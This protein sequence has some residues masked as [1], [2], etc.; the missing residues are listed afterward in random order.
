MKKRILT[1]V[2]AISMVLSLAACGNSA[3]PSNTTPS[4]AAPSSSASGTP[5]GDASSKY[6]EAT[7]ALSSA[8]F[9]LS[10]FGGDSGSR[11]AIRYQLYDFLAVQEQFGEPVDKLQGQMAKSMTMKN[12][13]TCEV[14]L[15]DYIKDC[16]GN[17][18]KASDVVWAYEYAKKQGDFGKIG[19]YMKSIKAMDDFTVEIVANSAGAGVMETLL[20]GVP[21]VSQ[22]WFEG[23]SDS[24]KTSNPAC[25]GTYKITE[26]VTGSTVVVEAV[27]DY[28]QTD[29]AALS[30]LGHQ[31]VDKIT[32]KVITEAAM[33][34]I[35][36]EN[37]ELDAAPVT[38]TEVHRFMNDDGSSKDGW[39]VLANE[40]GR[41]NVLMFNCDKG[42]VFENKTLRQAVLYAI[43]FEQVRLG[44]GN[45]ASSG[46]TMHD[47]CVPVAGDYNKAWDSEDYYSHNVEKA[48]TL[49][50]EAGYK[51]GQLKIRLMNQNSTTANAG[52]AVIQAFLGEIG[53]EVEILSYDQALFNTY[54]FDS[55]QW[56]I[57][58]D[59]K[60]T[61]DYVVS[62]WALCFDNKSF[63]NGTANF[64]HDD[65][66]QTLLEKSLYVHDKGSIDEFHN[67]LKEQAYG[68]GMFYNYAYIVAQSGITEI[69]LDGTRNIALNASTYVDNYETVVK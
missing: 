51:P 46:S 9:D 29:K 8:S 24:D 43:D 48:K 10:P 2:L 30:Y 68:V 16:Q 17:P 56:D 22:K 27:K 35:G 47:F 6:K 15:Y 26:L 23:A 45:T 12:E 49:L 57:I 31:P 11:H 65:M 69:G 54:K 59:S 40:N 55:T 41:F 4:G 33:R 67:Y 64:V 39:T 50:A 44:Y 34:T 7:Y 25:T 62:A 60:Y 42:S 61:T 66:L 1:L 5:S 38:A 13:V 37:K 18:I 58:V 32:Y 36:L 53:I 19:S 14:K 28:W 63:E 3:K 21:I 20:T 52:M